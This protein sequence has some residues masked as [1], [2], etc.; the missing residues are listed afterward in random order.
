M[1]R[2][3]GFHHAGVTVTSL[4]T[5]LRLYRDVLGLELQVRRR[6]TE[7][8]VFE[9]TGV[10]AV[11]VSVAFLSVP[12]SDAQVELLEYEGVRRTSAASSPCDPA[13]A[14]LC[15]LVEDLSALFER[16]VGAGFHARS[17]APV[18]I[19]VGPNAGGKL[20]YAVDPDGVFIELLEAPPR[21]VT[22]TRQ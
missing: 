21:E 6:I 15:L 8:Y 9:F 5:S 1:S 10:D 13:N 12:G 14:H 19:P 2:V 16:L 20:L 3:V 18:E 17:K 4:E 22:A 11:A 7:P